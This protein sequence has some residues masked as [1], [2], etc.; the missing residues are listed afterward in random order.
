MH[1]M[2]M[3]CSFALHGMRHLWSRFCTAAGLQCTHVS[4]SL[5]SW[6]NPP[7]F[8][9]SAA[10]GLQLGCILLKSH[11]IN[12]TSPKAERMTGRRGAS[13]VLCGLLP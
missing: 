2:R 10:S 11:F 9:H 4:G 3:L 5:P 13:R 8:P 7:K 12:P 6:V 1:A